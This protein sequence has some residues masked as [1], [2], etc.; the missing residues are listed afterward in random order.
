MPIRVQREETSILIPAIAVILFLTSFVLFCMYTDTGKRMMDWIQEDLLANKK[1]TILYISNE[2]LDNF[3]TM[4]TSI[5]R[6]RL[7]QIISRLRDDE[8]E[9]RGYLNKVIS[10]IESESNTKKPI[11]KSFIQ[12][13]S[14]PPLDEK[15]DIVISYETLVKLELSMVDLYKQI[16]AAQAVL[17]NPDMRFED[18][19]N[20]TAQMLPVRIVCDAEAIRAEITNTEDGKLKRL[21]NE[22]HRIQAESRSIQTYAGK[23]LGFARGSTNVSGGVQVDMGSAEYNLPYR[24]ATLLPDEMVPSHAFSMGD[25]NALPGRRIEAG[26]DPRTWMFIDTW[27]I[28]GPFPNQGRRFVNHK[29]MPETGVDLDASYEGKDGKKVKWEFRRF[30]TLQI[31]PGSGREV[32]YYGASDIWSDSERTVWFSCGS[33]DYGK[34][35][36]N[37]KEVWTSGQEPKAFKAD[38]H[39][40]QVTLKKGINSILFRN[41]N[42]GGTMAFCLLFSP[43]SD[44]ADDFDYE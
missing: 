12:N 33:D 6:E 34:L 14:P 11:D 41:E 40:G 39:L 37:N 7:N 22:L 17:Y 10:Q 4:I 27:Y 43:V 32:V 3:V 13:I 1:R 18:A 38:E 19:Y 26:A 30:D 44:G 20:S 31:V 25:F 23:L 8:L 16:R 15:A 24:G 36:I 2:Q 21:Q 9:L 28:I 29:F 5:Q 42:A 35:W